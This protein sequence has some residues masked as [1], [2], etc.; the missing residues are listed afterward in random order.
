MRNRLLPWLLIVATLL[1][2]SAVWLDLTPWLRGPDEWRWTLRPPLS[3]SIKLAVP[4][5][6]LGI[7]LAACSRCGS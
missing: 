3:V 6:A 5:A 2:V 7:Y 1:F 4:I